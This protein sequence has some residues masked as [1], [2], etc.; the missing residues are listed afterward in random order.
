[1]MKSIRKPA[2]LVSLSIVPTMVSLA[3]LPTP[4]FGQCPTATHVWVGNG[5]SPVWSQQANWSGGIVPQFGYLPGADVAVQHVEGTD[6]IELDMGSVLQPV[7]I[8]SY[9]TNGDE[10]RGL[11]IKN[12]RGLS[13]GTYMG[14]NN[15]QGGDLYHLTLEP[16]SFLEVGAVDPVELA[17]VNVEAAGLPNAPTEIVV[18]PNVGEGNW[19]LD[20]FTTLA[21]TR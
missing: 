18:H 21:V 19:R 5:T 9:C 6:V 11:I 10:G 16:G 3:A 14:W 1:M 7:E 20:P 13:V 17:S 2:T 8:D 12:G 15:L 4:V